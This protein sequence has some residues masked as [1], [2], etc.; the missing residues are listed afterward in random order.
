MIYV[1]YTLWQVILH[2]SD[3]PRFYYAYRIMQQSSGH[4]YLDI[5]L[6]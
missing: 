6:S 5:Q 4:L 3:Y 2:V 1:N